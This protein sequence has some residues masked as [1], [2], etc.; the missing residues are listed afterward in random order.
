MEK[1]DVLIVGGGLSGLSLA[2]MLA[3]RGIDYK[4]IEARERLGGRSGGAPDC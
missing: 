2:D 4:L 1:V 3:D